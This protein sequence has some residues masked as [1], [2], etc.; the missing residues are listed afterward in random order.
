MVGEPEDRALVPLSEL[1]VQAPQPSALVPT[2]RIRGLG[3]VLGIGMAI[4][5]LAELAATGYGFV[6]WIAFFVVYMIAMRRRIFV[7][8]SEGREATAALDAGDVGRATQHAAKMVERAPWYGP[9]QLLAIA[10][11]GLVELRRG[12]PESAAAIL[13]RVAEDSVTWGRIGR[14]MDMWWVG[15]AYALAEAV[16]GDVKIARR[17]VDRALA[18]AP[19]S[20][21]GTLLPT[22]VYILC[23]AGAW[24]DALDTVDGELRSAE[25][26]LKPFALRQVRMLEAFAHEHAGESYRADHADRSRRALEHA[27]EANRGAFDH[28]AVRWPELRQFLQRHHLADET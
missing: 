28:L 13:R 19:P 9:Y 20:M 7:V 4:A 5:G 25:A 16:A 11:W 26:Q 17:W 8:V 24:T 10:T 18:D 2:R 27:R 6:G 21:R 1:G 14:L 3:A 22:R 12:L 15:G 23:R